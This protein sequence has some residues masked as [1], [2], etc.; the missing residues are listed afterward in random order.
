MSPEKSNMAS[1]LKIYCYQAMFVNAKKEPGLS[2]FNKLLAVIILLS[3][4]VTILET[5]YSIYNSY[6]SHFY[7]FETFITCFF[8]AEY[9][10]R[11]WAAGCEERYRGLRGRIRF[12]MTFGALVDLLAFLPS[13]IML[14][15]INVIGSNAF[16]L[17]LVRLARLVRF[18]KLGRYSRAIRRIERAL[19][20]C[21]RELII[22]L[23]IA[24]GLIILGATV[25]YLVEGQAQPEVFGSIPR[26]LWWSVVT[27]TTVGYGDVYPITTLG[28][29]CTSVIA[30]IGVATVA[31]PAGILAA[32]FQK[33]WS[34]D[35]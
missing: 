13:L 28:K 14:G 21:M 27:L 1:D 10:T 18:A 26:A 2:I 24:C 32:A 25:I 8:C 4:L 5:E 15:G 30:F 35:E 33:S 22:S 11:I 12:I 6:T 31:L 29:I 7:Y 9:L 23:L 19:L 3:L 16:V 34:Q 17:R 20:S